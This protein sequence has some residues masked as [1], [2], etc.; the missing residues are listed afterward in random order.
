[1]DYNNG[2]I[3]NE[4]LQ[5]R[6]H[7]I[8]KL[9]TLMADIE[10]NYSYIKNGNSELFSEFQRKVHSLV[11]S[12][13]TFGFIDVS[14]K[15]RDLENYLVDLGNLTHKL[16]KVVLNKIWAHVVSMKSLI[17]RN[18]NQDDHGYLI[19]YRENSCADVSSLNILIAS[20][21]DDIRLKMKLDLELSSHKCFFANNGQEA[22]DIFLIENI[23]LIIIEI[24]MPLMD[25]YQTVS[26]IKDIM[27]SNYVPILFLTS[28]NR[29]EE[30]LKCID[31]GG[32]DYLQKPYDVDLLKAKIYAL[33][34]M[35]ELIPKRS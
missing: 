8:K 17:Q 14:K 26:R 7:Y 30:L 9:P 35:A 18:I 33:N 12:S 22:I 23:D 28:S 29:K 3:K 32:D 19:D 6:S 11:G 21:D 34:R 31:C 4:L 27:L 16:D 10:S 5:L 15:A 25:G 13:G 20:D 24:Y 1:M 2:R